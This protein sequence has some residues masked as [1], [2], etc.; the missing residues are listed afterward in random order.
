MNNY[1]FLIL[2]R[3]QG[4]Y[5][6]NV[7]RG[8]IGLNLNEWMEVYQYHLEHPEASTWDV[9]NLFN[10]SQKHVRNI[11]SYMVDGEKH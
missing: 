8:L 10:I 4:R 7:R 5:D 6:E 3:E 11:Y 9:A 2:E 1:Q